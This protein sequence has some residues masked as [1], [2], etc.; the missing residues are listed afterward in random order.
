[1]SNLL[2]RVLTALVLVP[3]ALALLW[4][5]GWGFGLLVAAVAVGSQFEVYALL[6]KAGA[7]PLTG[8]GLVLGALAAL[9]ALVP[10]AEPLLV[11]GSVAA[12]V[13]MLQGR[14]EAPLLDAA[15][16][17]LG[18]V[19]PALLLGYGLV[20]RE[21]EGVRL[22][23]LGG[24]WLTATVLVAG[25]GADTFAYG[26]GRAF[27]RHPLAPRVSPKKTWEGFAGGLLGALVVVAAFKL[28]ALDALSWLD[29]A[30]LAACAGVGGPLG[31]LA[32][33]LFKR[34]VDVKD[35]G[36]LLPG[37]GGILDRLD[38]M[39]VTVPL[40]TLYLDHVAGL[41]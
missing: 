5:G 14:R 3:L 20:L 1:M 40:A 36:R 7:R 39:A 35:S 23:A 30:A 13:A 9:R 2:Q 22:G 19:Y 12:V 6:R 15:G 21:A 18:V 25:W 8:L 11:L 16:T 29:V 34:S 31:D 24:F 28:L 17:F 4:V 38:A 37:H 41:F 32:E 10:F 33:S 27:G 26:A